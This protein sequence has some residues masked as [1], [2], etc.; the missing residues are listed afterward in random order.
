MNTVVRYKINNIKENNMNIIDN[1]PEDAKAVSFKAK[2]YNVEERQDLQPCMVKY[3]DDIFGAFGKKYLLLGSEQELGDT[4]KRFDILALDH[5]G[6][7]IIMELKRGEKPVILTQA[8]G[9]AGIIKQFGTGEEF[10]KFFP[11]KTEEIKSFLGKHNTDIED[12]NK[13]QAIILVSE[14]FEIK[15]RGAIV[16]MNSL[17]GNLDVRDQYIE[18][19]NVTLHVDSEDNHYFTFEFD[20]LEMYEIGLGDSS[21][22]NVPSKEEM[23]AKVN[24]EAARQF[25]TRHIDGEW[26]TTD[27]K[28]IYFRKNGA[29][30][31]RC[32]ITKEYVSVRQYA[33][34]RF[35]NDEEYWASKISDKKTGTNS[36]GLTFRLYTEKDFQVFE[37]S[38]K[39]NHQWL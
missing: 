38:M 17:L 6:R 12:L 11:H 24:N 16:W 27:N 37:D 4:R 1:L 32:S 10:F 23:I 26:Y 30:T 5:K 8:M 25:L 39:E 28:H 9:Y 13:E 21:S 31:W 35:E 14:G 36:K 3:F 18:A 20:E 7:P 29:R 2:E 33:N 19:L 34:F 22:E 15:T